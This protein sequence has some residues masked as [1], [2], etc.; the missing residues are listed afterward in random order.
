[1]DDFQLKQIINSKRN[2]AVRLDRFGV[3]QYGSH[4]EIREFI[5]ECKIKQV[6]WM[7]LIKAEFGNEANDIINYLSR[8]PR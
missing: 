7:E 8:N 2:S 3:P 6:N 1:M 5:D 4:H